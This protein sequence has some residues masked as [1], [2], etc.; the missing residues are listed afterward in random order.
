MDRRD[1][2]KLAGLAG[3]SLVTPLG[4]LTGKARAQ[5]GGDYDGPLWVLVNAAGG[6]DP[7][8]LCDPKGARTE[9]DPD[10]LNN[11]LADDIGESGRLRWAPVSNNEYFF[12]KYYRELLV[13]NGI[14]TETNGHDSG[15]RHTW[16][17]R[18]SRRCWRRRWRARSPCRSCPTAATSSPP[19]S[20]GRAAWAT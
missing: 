3:L 12:E 6:W 16:S 1:F 20:S 4:A 18:L 7:T 13:V 10:R 19:A 11:F 8:S 15:T 2:L 14:D 17:G 5:A 9:E